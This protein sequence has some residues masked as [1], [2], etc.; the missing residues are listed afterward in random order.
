MRY[1]NVNIASFG[2]ELPPNVVS[3]EDLEKR[4]TPLYA[5]LHFQKGQLESL[6]GIRERRF[7]DPG[8]RM[9]QGAILAGEK[10]I[11][12]AG[13]DLR[14]IQMLVYGGVCRDNLEPAFFVRHVAGV[15]QRPVHVP[16]GA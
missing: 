15:D 13:I 12:A 2:Y 6:T 14:S 1:S 11:A 5:A 16:L 7:W 3:S 9:A 8:F 4:L 10:A